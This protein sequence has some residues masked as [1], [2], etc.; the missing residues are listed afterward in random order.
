[1]REIMI[2]NRPIP[3][4]NLPTNPNQHNL[5]TNIRQ[6]ILPHNFHRYLN[7]LIIGIGKYTKINVII[8]VI[9]VGVVV[10]VGFLEGLLGLGFWGDFY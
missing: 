8:I 5:A 3:T 7:K 1:M 4:K 2:R 10:V 6:P 9:V